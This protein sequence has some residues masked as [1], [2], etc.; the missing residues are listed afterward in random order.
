ML[1]EGVLIFAG[2]GL[3]IFH[4]IDLLMILAAVP[5]IQ[6]MSR[7][8]GPRDKRKCVWCCEKRMRVELVGGLAIHVT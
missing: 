7:C 2:G 5:R 8:S 6:H 1:A 3:R 4:L